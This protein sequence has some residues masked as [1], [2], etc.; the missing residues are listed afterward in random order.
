MAPKSRGDE[1]FDAYARD[2]EARPQAFSEDL[3]QCLLRK[4][5]CVMEA[6]ADEG[7]LRKALKE[8]QEMDGE[9]RLEKPPDEI[10]EGLLGPAGSGRFAR[11]D[12]RAV[13]WSEAGDDGS[14]GVLRSFDGTMYSFG[15][16]MEPYAPSYL[17][18]ELRSRDHGWL[19]EAG[20]QVVEEAPPLR[21]DVAYEWISIFEVH[22]IMCLLF[23]G[24]G[25]GT[26]EMKPF[27]E[28]SGSHQVQIQ[29]GTWV[30]LRV[31]VLSHT[32][33]PNGTCYVQGCFY[34]QNQSDAEPRRKQ[35]D[36]DRV[37]IA[38]KLDTWLLQTVR[39]LKETTEN[40]EELE[41]MTSRPVQRMTNQMYHK[42]AQVAVRG[43]A[44]RFPGNGADVD[45]YR[46]LLYMG[47]DTAEYIPH[48]RWDN[49]VYYVHVTSE[50]L[51]TMANEVGWSNLRDRYNCQHGAFIE[52]LELFDNKFFGLS[53][54]ESKGMDPNQRHMLEICYEVAFSAGMKKPN[55]MKAHIGV[56]TAGPG[57]MEAEWNLVPK[58]DD[59]GGALASTSGSAAILSNRLSY[60]F[61]MQGPNF[62]LNADAA[63]S[64][65]A[66]NLGSD[67]LQRS[68][69]QCDA[70][71]CLAIDA[72]V[73]PLS[74]SQYCWAGHMSLTGRCLTF[75]QSADGY[76]RGEGSAGVYMNPYLHEVDGEV[77]VDEDPR[78]IGLV[79][80]VWASHS[81]KAASLNAP[82]GAQDQELIAATL[83]AAEISAL[84][85]DMVDAHGA[86]T[87]LSDAVETMALCRGLRGKDKSATK[88]V[89]PELLN[90]ASTKATC[91]NGKPLAGMYAIIKVL[92]THEMGQMA[93]TPHLNRLNPHI[94]VDDFP[95]F[96][97]GEYVP[98][99]MN[100]AFS[101]ITAKG[102]GGS[103]LH[104]I[105]WGG[106][107][108]DRVS[109]PKPVLNQL[110]IVYWPGGG[111]DLDHDWKP[112]RSYTVVGSWSVGGQPETLKSEG[113]GSYGITITMGE[114]G[115]E[116]FQ[117]MLDGDP[118][119][120]L[121]PGMA[122]AFKDGA[123]K[124]PDTA[125]LAEGNSWMIGGRSV[126]ASALALT[127]PGS[128]GEA[129]SDAPRDDVRPGDQYHIQLL[130]N[131]RY[132]MVTWS[133]VAVDNRSAVVPAKVPASIGRY[134][135]S[136]SWCDWSLQEMA[137]D[138]D[139]PGVYRIETMLLKSAGIFSI[140]RNQDW[141][142]LLYPATM[143]ADGDPNKAYGPDQWGRG[144]SWLIQGQPGDVFEVELQRSGLEA[145]SV[146]MQVSFHRLR[147][148]ELASE[149][150]EQAQ[151]PRYYLVGSWDRWLTR[152]KMTRQGDRYVADVTV[153]M[154]P[155]RFQILADG[156]W[157]RIL[158][159]SVVDAGLGDEAYLR[160]PDNRG[161]QLCW[162]IGTTAEERGG[163]RF[164]ITLLMGGVPG[165]GP[166]SVVWSKR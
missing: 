150:A 76:I 158:Y 28:D 106:I 126:G 14:G 60:T 162:V 110:E 41:A 111:G 43:H 34:F 163:G 132:R 90:L 154:E 25:S 37:P 59:G 99:R 74:Y 119:R 114:L 140:V 147:Q 17:G 8:V 92:L 20:S 104:A 125:D 93:P 13:P 112:A 46:A 83:R 148:E 101:G 45:C 67:S 161:S 23:L 166:K 135:F 53:V 22:R 15:E 72:I 29:P 56:Y 121:H 61:G 130:I 118:E 151:E 68:K 136:A 105:L 69:P 50:N 5:F 9:G 1:A 31:D 103:C 10:A 131:G 11:F 108:L 64:L 97:A 21:A 145:G 85:V 65:M 113:K 73:H 3:M 62:L 6:D 141:R 156:D 58:V 144:L 49:D 133:R 79:A 117:I 78:S 40:E 84:D 63:S 146:S 44:C 24:P 95:V 38:V 51:T 109:L 33:I 138:Q 70:A 36:F 4:G 124:G 102:F 30:V 142:Q 127:D 120:V 157:N 107:N 75:D 48:M 165:S 32:F 89:E 77:V 87:Q 71:F 134:Y 139:N 42:G 98:Q 2:C 122:D 94:E 81:G 152:H 129:A 91:G 18:Y 88:S 164:E 27:D 160:G 153:G 116:R 115:F 143:Y 82:S 35:R 12:E 86:S 96:F 47:T 26:L 159:P 123:V 57:T 52:G 16:R 80:G 155:E 19:L 7:D 55:L 66:L 128:G 149:L 54:M 39:T 137:E 100:S